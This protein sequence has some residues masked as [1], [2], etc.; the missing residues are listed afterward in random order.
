MGNASTLPGL[1]PLASAWP[2]AAVDDAGFLGLGK[3]PLYKWL[4]YDEIAADGSNV[5]K[6][7]DGKP[8]VTAKNQ[9]TDIKVLS[10]ALAAPPLDYTEHYYPTRVTTDIVLI[11]TGLTKAAP[12]TIHRG[13]F[14]K[15][16]GLNVLGSEG[17]A[18]AGSFGDLGNHIL[19]DG[20]NHLDVLLA[21][22]KQK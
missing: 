14:K 2:L 5:A 16:P 20:Y 3:G 6:S 18:V 22:R 9:V 13:A 8:F 7:N 19:C 11:G 15:R 21:A 12:N 4:N 1:L 10:A 17:L